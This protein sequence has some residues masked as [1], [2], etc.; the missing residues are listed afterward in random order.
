MISDAFKGLHEF[1][2]SKPWAYQDEMQQFL[3]DDFEIWVDVSTISW[4]LWREKISRKR[5]NFNAFIDAFIDTFIDVFSY[6]EELFNGAN[7]SGMSGKFALQNG[8][9][10]SSC[11]LTNL[12]RMN[13]LWIAN[14]DGHA[15]APNV[16][17]QN[18]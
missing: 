10:I 11:L 4:V 8:V 5:Y 16:W 6:N 17:L 18:S 12:L 7:A 15:L 2:L 1:L 14:T 9:L 3:Y 13:G